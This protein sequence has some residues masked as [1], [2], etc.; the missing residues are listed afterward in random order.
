VWARGLGVAA[1]ALGAAVAC[2]YAWAGLTLSHYDAKGHLVVAR[3]IADSL[4]PGWVQ[5]GAVWL[6]LP[7]LISLVPVQWDL[8]Y[9]TGAFGVALSVCC[10][11][12]LVAS[13]ARLVFDL[14]RSRLAATAAALPVA[15]NPSVLYL[16]STPMTEP[17]LMA[18]LALS[19][20]LGVEAVRSGDR[21]WER[22]AGLALAAAVLTRYEA[23]PFAAVLLG[24]VGLASCRVGRTLR[25]SAMTAVRIAIP[26][27]VA[28]LAFLLLSRATVGEWF[29]QS[30][31]FVAENPDASRPLR[32]LV[33]VWWGLHELSS[34]PLAMLGVAGL[35]LLLVRG[36]RSPALAPWLPALA[37]SAVAALPCYAFYSGHPFRIRYMIPL[38]PAMGLGIGCAIGLAGRFKPIVAAVMAA[39][40]VLAPHPLDPAAPMVVEAQWDR[41]HREGRAE[42]AA[43]LRRHWDGEP[44]MAS[45]GSLAHFMQELSHQG[46]RIRDFLHEGN[47]DIW[48]AA[49]EY[50]DPHVRWVLIEEQAEGG[51]ILA[52]RAR[53]RPSFLAGYDRV[54]EGGGV[55]LYRKKGL[56]E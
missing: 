25:A 4:T 37:L 10:A 50:P 44:I 3:R 27:G 28:I 18:L 32:A 26:P 39:A 55:A 43:Y 19:S 5:I 38:I 49:V 14:T 17:L 6:P 41:P 35:V 47:G 56:E 52:V 15:L 31:F 53:S 2:W 8:L 33:S 16:Q 51:D 12:V 1:I 20:W 13:L 24:L 34:Y 30:G 29:V 54:A 48:L 11:G 36:L 45:M 23:W 21:S 42:V 40:M 46:L 7:H 22:R 9:R